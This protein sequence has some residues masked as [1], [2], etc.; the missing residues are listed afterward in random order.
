MT[1]RRMSWVYSS[2]PRARRRP[3]L[4]RAFTLPDPAGSAPVPAGR[5]QNCHAALRGP[6]CSACGQHAISHVHSVW[7]FMREAME[8]LTH[9]DSRV[10]STLW[11]LLF[12]PGFLT[13]EFL[14]GRRAR[15]LPPLR[16]YLV[17]S[18]LFFL[19]LASLPHSESVIVDLGSNPA[20]ASADSKKA[21]CEGFEYEGPFRETLGPRLLDACRRTAADK[22][23]SL[24]HAF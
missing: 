16:L 24:G 3:Q 21:P 2:S 9:A 20:P 17:V 5:C 12:R 4:S 7:E 13:C 19:L 14:N 15:Y 1:L 22:G 23:R 11:P 6:Y 18:V 8:G 10:W